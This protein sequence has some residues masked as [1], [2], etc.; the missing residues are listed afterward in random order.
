MHVEPARRLRHVA[1]AQFVDALDVLPAHAIGRHRV[2][3]R[4]GVLAVKREQGGHHVVGVDR[5]GEVVDRAHLHRVHRGGD[6]A[7]AGQDDGAGVG[8]AAL[9][10]G[11]HVEAVAV[12]KTHVDHRIG[13]RGGLQMDQ[14]VGDR[15]GGHHS[16]AAAL[17]RARQPLQKRLVVLDD[18][19]SA[20]A[21]GRR[22]PAIGDGHA[23][24][25]SSAA[26]GDSP[27]SMRH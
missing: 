12:A 8:A 15:L 16:E 13:R 10:R 24:S 6:V 26:Q 25:N 19:K 17:H 3:R 22:R 5:L 23:T 11:D 4:L 20:V 18:Q 2:F 7:V 27:K 14:P 1:S 9:E 21:R